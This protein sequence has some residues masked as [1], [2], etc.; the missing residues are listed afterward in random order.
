MAMA[1][2]VASV[3]QPYVPAVAHARRAD[4]IASLKPFATRNATFFDA[5]LAS[6]RISSPWPGYALRAGRA[7]R[8]VLS[9]P[10]SSVSNET[11]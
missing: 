6:I 8:S 10:G 9:F 2:V 11:W 7:G 3:P 4:Q 1:M 5:L